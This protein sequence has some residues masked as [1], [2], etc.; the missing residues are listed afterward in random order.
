M[1]DDFTADPHLD[2]LM[3]L[4]D[5]VTPKH[6]TSKFYYALLE[7]DRDRIALRRNLTEAQRR[8]KECGLDN[9]ERAIRAGAEVIAARDVANE[10]GRADA[11]MALGRK[12]ETIRDWLRLCDDNPDGHTEF[13]RECAEITFPDQSDEAHNTTTGRLRRADRVIGMLWKSRRY[14]QFYHGGAELV[15]QWAHSRVVAA[16]ARIEAA[17]ELHR[18][19]PIYRLA[20]ERCFTEG[21]DTFEAEDGEMVCACAPP[22][23]YCC[24]ECSDDSELVDH[25]CATARA[26]NGEEA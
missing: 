6:G 7:A 24:E 1:A 14:W 18:K 20:E 5:G 10:R 3:T 15:G 12:Y 23:G 19:V 9:L 22:E 13:Y 17:L 11:W 16:E 4:A 21:H 2:R 25:P 8:A 26:L